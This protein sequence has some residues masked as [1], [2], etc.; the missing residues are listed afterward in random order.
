MNNE[1]NFN[2]NIAF[3][4]EITTKERG[5]SFSDVVFL[6]SGAS[7]YIGFDNI[8]FPSLIISRV[9]QTVRQKQSE[10]FSVSA[11]ND[12]RMSTMRPNPYLSTGIAM[13]RGE[14]RGLLQFLSRPI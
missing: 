4:Q 14:F 10:L 1:L 7:Y 5:H 11:G 3:G 6:L 9:I 2:E 8:V 12:L 13:R